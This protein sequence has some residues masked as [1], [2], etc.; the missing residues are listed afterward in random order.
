MRCKDE[1]VKDHDAF[2]FLTTKPNDI[3]SPI[4]GGGALRA[5]MM[6]WA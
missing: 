5:A 6:A 3:V 1:G 4:Q 2:A